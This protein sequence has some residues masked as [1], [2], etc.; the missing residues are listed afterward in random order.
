MPNQQEVNQPQK[1][2]TGSSGMEYEVETKPDPHNHGSV[3]QAIKQGEINGTVLTP[4]YE[5]D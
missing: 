4:I 5:G 3:T 2:V 1:T